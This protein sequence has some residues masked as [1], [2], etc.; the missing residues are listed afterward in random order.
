MKL[1]NIATLK[2]L[3]VFLIGEQRS[4]GCISRGGPAAHSPLKDRSALILCTGMPL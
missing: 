4:S 3:S 1:Q 2:G